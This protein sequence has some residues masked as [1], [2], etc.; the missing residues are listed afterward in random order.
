MQNVITACKN[1]CKLVYFDMLTIKTVKSKPKKP[2]S[3]LMGKGRGK[4]AAE[5]LLKA[6]NNEIE[7]VICRILWSKKDSPIV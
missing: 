1:N 6:I 5:L 4:L 3:P 7:A 2:L